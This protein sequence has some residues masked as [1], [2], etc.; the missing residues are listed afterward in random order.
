MSS[1]STSSEPQA[2][3]SSG[4]GCG[5]AVA[6]DGASAGYKRALGGVIAI[7]VIGFVVVAVGSLWAGSASLAANTLDFAADAATYALSLWAIG[8]SV[9]VR[10]GAAF[11]KSGSLAV[12]ALGILGFAVWRAFVGS[13]PEGAAISGLGLFGVA[14]NLLAALLL[15]RYREGDANVRS[16]WLCTRNDLIQCLAVAATGVAVI[17]TG[18]RWPDLIVGVL[19][20]A[21]FLRSAW[22]ITAQALRESKPEGRGGQGD[23]ITHS[24]SA[25]G[26]V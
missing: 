6:F 1:C 2:A 4:C 7:N 21:V 24:P 23:T 14:A 19:L 26:P 16:V 13:P 15:V 22:Q 17:T 8:K 10:S 20:A 9:Q 18:S 25:V 5:H 3:S 12:M 11:I